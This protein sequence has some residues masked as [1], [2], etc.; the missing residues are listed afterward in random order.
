MLHKKNSFCITL[1][2][3]CS[4]QYTYGGLGVPGSLGFG[5]PGF[6]WPWPAVPIVKQGY[7]G[8]AG[9]A[10]FAGGGPSPGIRP[11]AI[12]KEELVGVNECV[13][14]LLEEE[15]GK[16]RQRQ[17]PSTGSTK[18][19]KTSKAIG[20][21]FSGEEP[22]DLEVFLDHPR[23]GFAETLFD[24]RVVQ[25]VI[26]TYPGFYTKYPTV[27]AVNEAVDKY[28]PAWRLWSSR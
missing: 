12:E 9:S 7:P 18:K 10:G 16:T 1:L 8:V 4:T 14:Q 28:K 13:W 24:L 3:C 27:K 2:F 19:P 21:M 15:Q 11:G 6:G 26:K 22:S 23:I 5:G 17:Q 20:L 25:H